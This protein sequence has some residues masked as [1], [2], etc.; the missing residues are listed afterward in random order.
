M[1]AAENDQPPDQPTEAAAGAGRELAGAG[2][3]AD[4]S[5]R[6]S[7]GEPSYDELLLRAAVRKVP[8]VAYGRQDLVVSLAECL[9]ET[10][11]CDVL[12]LLMDCDTGPEVYVTAP[13]DTTLAR[14]VAEGIVEKFCPDHAVASVAVYHLEGPRHPQDTDGR[15]Q[16]RSELFIPVRNGRVRLGVLGL[17][18]VDSGAFAPAA[19]QTPAILHDEFTRVLQF[20]LRRRALSSRR[21]TLWENLI[22]QM[23]DRTRQ[24]IHAERLASLGLLSVGVA[25]EIGNPTAHIQDNIQTFQ[26]AWPVI[27]R[28]LAGLP[29]DTRQLQIATEEM[30]AILKAVI[31]AT[32]RITHTVQG[33]H[34][35]ARE[36]HGKHTRADRR[37]G[38]AHRACR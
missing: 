6:A 16:P 23:S 31:N 26:R 18:S 5:M 22:S 27:E 34:A 25:H 38:R 14:G 13:S 28:A 19:E 2:V 32:D 36:D 9:H 20:M 17:F 37:R 7:E 35:H 10:V 12:A 33:L 30:P 1:S 11:P 15:G 3:V 8:L 4:P 29:T 24:L 21:A